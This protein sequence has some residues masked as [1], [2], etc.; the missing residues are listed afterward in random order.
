MTTISSY[1]PPG[2]LTDLGE[3]GRKA[4]DVFVSDNID[5]AI[6]GPDPGEVLHDSPRSQ[7]YNLTKT[8]T[9]ADARTAT[10]SWT[11]FPRILKI[12]STS[13]AQRWKKAEASR[14][15]QDEYCEWSVTRRDG[16]IT[17]AAFT[18]ES[19]E[20][21]D[22]L[23]KTSPETVLRLYRRHISPDVQESDLFVNGEYDRA[24]KWNS[25]TTNGAMH[26]IQK[27][28]TLA[29]EI[30]LAAAGTIRRVIDGTELTAEQE[31]IKCSAY[32]QAERNSDPHIGASVNALARQKASISLAD[33]V[34][35]YF[36]GLS[37]EGWATPDGSDPQSYWTY[38]RGEADHRVRAVYEV[39]AG[40]D[41]T[42]GDITI[43]GRPIQYG[44]QIAD[45]ITI[46]LMA[47]ACRFGQSTTEPQTACKQEAA[48]EL[49][50]PEEAF[51]ASAFS[52]YGY[53]GTAPGRALRPT[54]NA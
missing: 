42:V 53:L 11:A 26:L 47:V 5:A 4:W 2:G 12:S 10:V 38:E 6:Q 22:V 21:W 50:R 20:Y 45:F 39:P 13:D 29:A 34:G 36:D 19:P 7:F 32:G 25:T 40:K 54:R 48:T 31:L 41:F 52:A 1:G 49:A 14:K 18:C 51:V 27:N 35:L 30:E 37:T 46:K 15:A 9:A 3:F 44:A 24:N 16:K 17:K 33:P 28:N 8:D 43:N 23:A